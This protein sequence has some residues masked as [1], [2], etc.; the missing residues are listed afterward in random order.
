MR[1]PDRQI[2]RICGLHNKS[3][4]NWTRLPYPDALPNTSRY[5]DRE[6]AFL[7]SP[8]FTAYPLAPPAD[9]VVV[10][11][12]ARNHIRRPAFSRVPSVASVAPVD[13]AP[14]PP[15]PLTALFEPIKRACCLPLDLPFTAAQLRKLLT[16][17][18]DGA[19]TRLH[20]STHQAYADSIDQAF[21]NDQFAIYTDHPHFP[22]A[23]LPSFNCEP[24]VKSSLP[25]STILKV[26]SNSFH[27]SVIA[28]DSS[29]S[30]RRYHVDRNM[31]HDHPAY[32]FHSFSHG[33]RLHDDIYGG[34]NHQ[35]QGK[36]V[37]CVVRRNEFKAANLTLAESQPNPKLDAQ[38]NLDALLGCDSFRV[39]V[40]SP[41]ETLILPS[42]YVHGV[43]SFPHSFSVSI[44]YT[45]CTVPALVSSLLHWSL[46]PDSAP[47]EHI[48]GE[49][50][51]RLPLYT[52]DLLS[53]TC[54]A[55]LAVL[56]RIPSKWRRGN[57]ATKR[58]LKRIEPLLRQQ[59]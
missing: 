3:R 48:L 26:G 44:A 15:H 14:T 37:W 51:E 41:R 47:P 8:H 4:S 5:R 18:H 25:D 6:C 27:F 32:Q 21:V 33:T 57:T 28:P 35:L 30:V 23:P 9:A 22:D 55:L 36:K 10:A 46:H 58:L 34:E 24:G 2:C 50:W 11:A 38:Y 39:F 59:C 49:I 42:C 52:P 54:A 43:F 1:N 56:Q 31:L 45:L 12:R 16:V 13:I 53:D 20:F 29:A 19:A 7:C 17:F 40:L